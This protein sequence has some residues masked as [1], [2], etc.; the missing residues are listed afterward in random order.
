MMITAVPGALSLRWETQQQQQQH[1]K[2]NSFPLQQHRKSNNMWNDANFMQ[3]SG[4]KI[5]KKSPK[6]NK[7]YL[8]IKTIFD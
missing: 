2:K 5:F 7:N 1:L 3:I 4:Y 6:L 8:N